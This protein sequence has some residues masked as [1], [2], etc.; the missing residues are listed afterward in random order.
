M[1]RFA[2]RSAIILL[3]AGYLLVTIAA[4]L[5]HHHAHLL[6]EPNSPVAAH[7]HH[8]HHGHGHSHTH[9]HKHAQPAHGHPH[10]P[11]GAP[12]HDDDCAVCQILATKTVS[13]AVVA[14]VASGES[15]SQLG[16][17]CVVVV[18]VALPSLPPSRGPPATT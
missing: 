3:A 9:P 12:G 8:D 5:L 15:F 17:L 1:A 4:P 7:Q 10:A 16:P 2:V 11:H 14:V 18:D 6:S 13:P